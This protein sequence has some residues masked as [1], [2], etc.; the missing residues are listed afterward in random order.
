LRMIKEVKAA[1]A[2]LVVNATMATAKR[3]NRF[4]EGWDISNL[5]VN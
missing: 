1:L 5:L 3:D 4:F 2:K